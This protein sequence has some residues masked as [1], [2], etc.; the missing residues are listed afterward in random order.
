MT[1]ALTRRTRWL[2]VGGA[3]ALAL[4]VNFA[5]V[6]FGPDESSN[7]QEIES[8]VRSEWTSSGLAPRTVTCDES[9]S[10]WTCEI[11]SAHG[12]TVTCR[13]GNASVFFANPRAALGGSCR[14]D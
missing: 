6:A 13:V 14:T 2:L 5:W 3:V 10:V 1:S 9:D 7:S 4:A 8:A 11:K 12:D